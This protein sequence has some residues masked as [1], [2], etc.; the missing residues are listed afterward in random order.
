MADILIKNSWT[1]LIFETKNKAYGAFELRRD[2]DK[3]IIRALIMSCIIFSVSIAIPFILSVL[4]H[5][6]EEAEMV[7]INL[8][9]L[10]PPPLDPNTP[11]PP[12]PPKIEAPKLAAAVKFVPPKV[13]EDEK[14][15]EE[16][17]PTVDDMK[18]KQISTKDVEGE[19]ST[20]EVIE[21]VGPAVVEE[22]KD[23][24]FLVVEEMPEFDGGMGG[25][26]KHFAKNIKYPA[27]AMEMGTT[28]RVIVS[29][30]VNKDGQVVN[31][32]ILKGIGDGCDE[33]ALRVVKSLPN[34]KPGKQNGRAASVKF[35]VPINFKLAQ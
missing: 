11:P 30:V 1:S 10:P 13:V 15:T 25:L 28:G 31:P 5:S 29:F 35:T 34:W 21:E 12:P 6:K 17:P 8:E 33:E 16:D 14:V 27:K 32:E 3:Y 19:K 18:D 26:Q 22:V 23:E 20:V 24:V 7:E 4:P 2:Y 9:L